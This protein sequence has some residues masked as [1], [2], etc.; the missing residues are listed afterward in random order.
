MSS[1]EIPPDLQQFVD[2]AIESGGFKSAS[3]VV[4]EA[5]RL[6][7]QRQQRL[8]QLRTDIRPA[9][10][11]LDRGEGIELDDDSLDGLFEDVKSRAGKRPDTGQDAP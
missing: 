1:V 11:R 6:L 9:L 10:K 3:E 8:Q 7:Q 5:L 4:G 2:R